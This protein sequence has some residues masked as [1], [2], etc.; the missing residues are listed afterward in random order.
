M[1]ISIAWVFDHI[2]AD[3]KNINIADLAQQ[4]IETT[5]EIDRVYKIEIDTRN[6]TCAQVKD[7][8]DKVTLHSPE[9][10]KDFILPARSDARLGELFL[11]VSAPEIR[12][13]TMV[14]LAS[15]KDG[16]FPS[17]NSSG[18]AGG[19]SLMDGSWKTAL[20]TADYIFEVDNKSINHRPDLWG[21][22]GIAREMAA[23]LGLKLK[24]LDAMLAPVEVIQYENSAPS[25]QDQPIAITLKEPKKCFRFGGWFVRNVENRPSDLFMAARLARVDGR[26][27]DAIV[28]ATNYA[29]FDVGHPMHAFDAQALNGKAI[30]VRNAKK[31][32]KI[33]LLDGE[34]LSLTADD[35]I[36]A[37]EKSPIALTGIMGGI[38]AAVTAKTTELLLEAACF[39]AAMIRTTAERV[40]KRTEASTRFEKNLD[41]NNNLNVLRR[42]AHLLRDMNIPHVLGT[43]LSSL[44]KP[45]IEPELK[46][47]HEYIE[48]RLGAHIAPAQ[49]IE[50]LQRVDFG[51]TQ[52]E[53][54]GKVE[55]VIKVPTFRATKDVQGKQDIMEEV[56]R[57][58]G[59][60]NIIP[61]LPKLP[62][63]PADLH[64]FNQ[65]NKIKETCAFVGKMHEVANYNFFDEVFI[66]SLGWEPGETLAVR[67][68]VS[69]NWQRLVT[70]LIPNLFKG[71]QENSA[72]YD[73]LRFF[74]LA[75]IYKPEKEITESKR[76]AGILF[77][78]KKPFSFYD[79]KAVLHDLF[80]RL[81]LPVTWH[82]VGL[83]QTQ[84]RRPDEALKCEEWLTPYQTAHIKSGD[85]IIGIAGMVPHSFLNKF[86]EGNA[87]VFDLDADFLLAYRA[88]IK[89]FE[90]LSKYQPN[91][92]DISL[93]LPASE[94]VAAI[95]QAIAHAD[96][97]I[98][99]V[100]LI[101]FL[102]KMPVKNNEKAEVTGT[103]HDQAKRAAT[104]RFI[105][106]QDE[107][108]LTKPEIDAIVQSVAEAVTA[109][110]AVIR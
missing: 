1:K 74:E 50:L 32:E 2:D 88:P 80:E 105:I 17:L 67:S 51:V 19:I 20:Q 31:G 5:A 26:P 71:I 10:N 57:L 52:K 8:S 101:D 82:K 104:F 12:W 9:L 92:R 55:Y 107:K 85:T 75:R 47:D 102:E 21:H 6:L 22:R 4:F 72:D 110:D 56:G 43:T 30:E 76:L 90:S 29:M 66:Q 70:T 34:E 33:R 61:E 14:D 94:T 3:W 40:K 16:L 27:I 64:E 78:K 96:S 59:Y 53:I 45:A 65:L 89:R 93:L 79:G 41:P 84:G 60:K 91:V 36:V 86:S 83:M 99:D 106:R 62:L 23:M 58:F 87:F 28:D 73:Q 103:E 68:P 98:D 35:L 49:V 81:A 38:E 39:D 24:P 108:T 25:T 42:F 69:Q 44:G 77:E 37:T 11:I 13:A 54:N 46:V 95:T 7:I 18:Q 15:G 63:K 48:S 109:R 97:R 100:V